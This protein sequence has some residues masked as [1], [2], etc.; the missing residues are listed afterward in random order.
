MSFNNADTHFSAST[1]LRS[2]LEK[3]SRFVKMST[4]Q[5]RLQSRYGKVENLKHRKNRLRL[6]IGSHG[7][8][9]GWLASNLIRVEQGMPFFNNPLTRLDPHMIEVDGR[10]NLPFDYMKETFGKHPMELLLAQLASLDENDLLSKSSNRLNAQNTNFDRVLIH[11]AHGLLMTEAVVR[12]FSCPTLLVVT[13]PIYSIDKALAEIGQDLMA[14]YLTQE[15]ESVGDPA[16]LLRFMG[17]KTRAFRKVYQKVR[18]MGDGEDARVY[19]QILTLAA[20]NRMFAKLSELYPKVETLTLRDLI[21]T[22]N[23][24][25]QLGIVGAQQV[26]GIL[27]PKDD[28]RPDISS[29]TASMTGRPHRISVELARDAYKLLAEAGLAELRPMLNVGQDFTGLHTSAK[30]VVA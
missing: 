6:I 13:D 27:V 24:I 28:F 11:E 29:I 30:V 1:G 26:Q 20:I 21:L 25:Y 2:A 12:T 15:F 3:T 22:P 10:W 4:W 16:F 9:A 23:L 19:R 5:M 7:S 18:D 8:G 14:N 17:S